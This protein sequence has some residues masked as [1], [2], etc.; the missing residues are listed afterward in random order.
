MVADPD[1]FGPDPTL[2]PEPAFEKSGSESD[3]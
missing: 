3:P 2:S 1:D